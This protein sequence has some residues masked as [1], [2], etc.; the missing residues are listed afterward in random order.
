MVTQAEKA[1]AFRAL[2]DG[3]EGFVIPNPW[4]IGSARLL[5][6]LGFKALATTSAG[7]AFSLGRPDNSITQELA[8]AHIRQLANAT[9]LPLSADLENG[10]GDRPEEA[11][12]TIRLAAEAGAVGG[13]IEDLTRNHESPLYSLSLAAER[14]RAAAEAARSLPFPFLLTARAENYFVG[15]PSL[16]DTIERLQ[17]YQ[18]AGADVLFAPGITSREDIAEV[19]RSIDRPLN[20]LMGVSGMTLGARELNR[21]GVKRFSVGGSLARAALGEF[22]RAAAEL[23]EHGTVD[24]AKTAVSGKELNELFGTFL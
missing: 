9:E 14:I 3:R 7:H 18:E 11:A 19:V 16:K 23:M 13:S 10:F 4:D 8:L 2:H 5:S 17:A 24:Y 1:L 12:R 22:S 20:V 21:L 15:R 6:K